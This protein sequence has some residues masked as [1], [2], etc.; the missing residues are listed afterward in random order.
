MPSRDF[1]Q[2]LK[3]FG[4]VA[5]GAA[6][7]ASL[8]M[9]VQAANLKVGTSYDLSTLDPHF[10]A[11]FPTGTSHSYIYDRLVNQD[12]NTK[13]IPGLADSWK[14]LDSTTWE[15]KLRKG[16]KFHDGSNFDAQDV[17]ATFERIPAVPDTPNSFTKYVSSIEK[18]EAPDPHTLIIKTKV[19]V[20]TLPRYFTNVII[21]RA[22]DKNATTN[23]FN[24]GHAI[25]TGPYKVVEWKRGEKLV[26]E[27]FK[28][29]WGPKP[30]WD[31]VEEIV[32]SNDS[33]RVAALL[34][35]SVDA[36]NF[37]PVTDVENLR[38]DKKF[39]LFSGP[40][41]QVHYIAMDSER[42][43]S[44]FV[45]GGKAPNPLKDAR[46][47]KAMSLA[48]NRKAIVDRLLVGLGAPA[49]QLLPPTFEGTSPN[50]KP[51]P[52]DPKGAKKL[53]AD[54]GFKDGFALTLHATNGRYPAD[55]EIAQAVAQMWSAI[56]LKVEVEGVAST[57]F[58]PRATKFEFSIYT[59]QYGTPDAL[60]MAISMLHSRNA[61]KGLGNGNRAHY[62]NAE[63]DKIVE[64]A[65]VELD[66]DKR[67]ELLA[68]AY[69]TVM[70]DTGIIP[71]YNPA[72][73]CAARDGLTLDIQADARLSAR[74]VH[75]K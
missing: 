46:V 60:D 55:S 50:L 20:P 19:P 5:L 12:L 41:G 45:N 44:P 29:Y 7:A 32:L 40:I 27:A 71:L 72:F 4:S 70:G 18:V 53:L 34:A 2:T 56:G 10:F 74:N 24:N 15:F 54:A 22:E 66:G 47:R 59:A 43:E 49:G 31:N 42:D 23:D 30:E 35:G 25:G 21:I 39:N 52:F 37:V 26:M 3:C 62:S 63:A 67:S 13:L 38:A 58:F 17:I 51:D 48:I 57:V 1:R 14:A 36:I 75:V 8:A 11:A 69:E 9:S 73:V 6:V 61:E 28:E 64:A 65:M 16:V 33:A 68:K